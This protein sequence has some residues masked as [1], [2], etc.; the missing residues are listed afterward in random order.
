MELVRTARDVGALAS[1]GEAGIRSY[2]RTRDLSA[3]APAV[4]GRPRIG[5]RIDSLLAAS[6]GDSVAS[7]LVASTRDAYVEWDRRYARPILD[8]VQ[9][10]R[11]VVVAPLSEQTLFDR[12]R[13]AIRAVI[14]AEETAVSSGLRRERLVSII[15]LIAVFGELLVLAVVLVASRRRT[16]VLAG[17]IS[18]Q[19][20]TLEQQSL[21]LETRATAFEHEATRSRSL[22]EYLRTTNRELRDSV[23]A[24]TRSREETASALRERDE[25]DYTLALVLS[26][27]PFGVALLD[28]ELRFERANSALARL[29]GLSPEEH[30]GRHFRD[31]VPTLASVIEPAL[32]EALETE[33][34][35]LG[36]EFDGE[37]ATEAGK[38]RHWTLS[39]YP[40]RSQDGSV[41]GVGAILVDA[42]ER[43]NL[44][45]QLL[46]A[47]KMEAVGRLAGSIAHDFNNL[48][49]AISAFA[50]FASEE[51]GDEHASRDDLGQI[52]LATERGTALTR[53]LLAFS[54][55]QFLHPRALDLNRLI[56]SLE[57]L[58]Q[59]LLGEDVK[60][61]LRLTSDLWPVDVDPGQLE[62]VILNLA[63]NA[64]DAMPNGGR[65]VI[66]SS[67]VDLDRAFAA[68]HSEVTPG[69]FVMLAVSDNGIGMDA[70]TQAHVFE[71]FFTTKPVGKGTGL[72]LSTVYGIVKQSRGDIFLYSERGR[73]TT[74]KIYFP[75]SQ[76]VVEPVVPAAA[77]PSDASLP[78]L[79]ILLVEDD[80]AVR[81]VVHRVLT[82]HGSTVHDAE[83]GRQAFEMLEHLG[84][85]V[86]LI[87]SDLVMPEM[88]GLEF[89][90]RVKERWP[91]TRV[92]FMSGYTAETAQREA[93]L[94][95]GAS[96][97][98]KPFTSDGL[99][100][101][102]REAMD[103]GSAAGAAA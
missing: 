83:N 55:Q 30:V 92:L 102:I 7:G 20:Q 64:R 13:V 67:N 88:G 82:R 16:L 59:R 81:H 31:V 19:Q 71:P 97:I 65:L 21:E 38:R 37:S 75:R 49:T 6:Q 96:F 40:V 101:K 52:L 42:T 47:Q 100:V 68:T 60:L 14:V 93:L 11:P 89:S 56:A 70:G 95:S 41:R 18:E 77:A 63:V 72:G 43:K 74:F 5:P 17:R 62:Q 76:H 26:A 9:A 99:L 34:P 2:L 86:D 44:E 80:S 45:R 15:G 78:P 58:M 48:L 4:A 12:F 8:S 91:K 94:D 32:V 24:L 51:L 103:P 98:E 84:G 33:R 54:R 73:G 29:G 85:G 69:P 25:T 57:G 23:E 53:R 10:G 35:V 28:R 3:I 66:E 87:L 61:D 50:Q 90:R 27:A 79:I 39:A 22:A 46:H 1:D 36:V